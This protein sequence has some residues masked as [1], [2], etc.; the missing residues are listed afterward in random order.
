MGWNAQ[1]SGK[2]YP[3]REVIERAYRQEIDIE[4]GK[5]VVVG[6]NKFSSGATSKIKIHHADEKAAE[7]QKKRVRALKRRR[8]PAKVKQALAG[9]R[10]AAENDKTNMVPV[11]IEA[12]KS[13]ATVGEITSA[14][15]QVFGTYNDPGLAI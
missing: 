15:K 4:T 11:L 10:G 8:D 6:R 9:V 7:I 3:Q 13:Y 2:G 1:R 5:R 12:V 14:M